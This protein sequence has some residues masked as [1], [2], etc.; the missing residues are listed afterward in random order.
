MPLGS[1]SGGRERIRFAPVLHNGFAYLLVKSGPISIVLFA[2]SMTWLYGVG[3]RRANSVDGY[4]ERQASRVLQAI[5]VGLVF[6]TIFIS[7]VFNRLDMFPYM[8]AAGFLL[9]ALCAKKPEER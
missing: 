6:A 8:L 2:Y 9:G 4:I 5:A 1:S 7:G 3:R